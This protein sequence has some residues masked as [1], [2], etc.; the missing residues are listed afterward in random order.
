MQLEWWSS[1]EIASI[2][3]AEITSSVMVV[4][5]KNSVFDPR[6]GAV[7]HGEAC[8][9]CHKTRDACTGHF[10]HVKLARPCYHPYRRAKLYEMLKQTC[11]GCKQHCANETKHCSKCAFP[12]GKW[13]RN[14]TSFELSYT[15][16]QMRQHRSILQSACRKVDVDEVVALLGQCS[17]LTLVSLPVPP[18]S[19]RPSVPR[20]GGWSHDPLSQHYAGIV[21]QNNTLSTYVRLQRP[22]HVIS[23][24]WGKLQAAVDKLFD[25]SDERL[26]GLRQRLDGKQGRFRK[27]L[28]GKRVNFSA[29][30]VITGDPSLDVDQV[31]VPL[32]IAMRLTV[33][34][35]VTRHNKFEMQK[36]VELG[37]HTLGGALYVI[38]GDGE[39]FDLKY[40]SRIVL[41]CGDVV[42]RMLKNDDVVVMNRQPT[43]HRM[44][45][46]AHRVKV[47]PYSTFRL[48]LCVTTPYNAVSPPSPTFSAIPCLKKRP[49]KLIRFC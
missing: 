19:I 49:H 5:E 46:M 16:V 10:G 34:V 33:P 26:P 37:A 9:T 11:V 2:S 15:P 17:D 7:R 3:V 18:F 42:E 28:Q 32:S 45:M 20:Y 6:L 40:C 12:I 27:T 41:G 8:I 47:L 1:D 43:L 22:R 39:Q 31:G 14:N 21:K 13:R 48:N 38:R 30:S 4:G 23:E 35:R 24:Q 44:S 36:H 25:S 29:R